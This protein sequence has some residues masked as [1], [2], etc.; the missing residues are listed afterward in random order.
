MTGGLCNDTGRLMMVFIPGA[1]RE[2]G[3]RSPCILLGLRTPQTVWEG[4]GVAAV[5]IVG[6]CD[7]RELVS[8]D[9][10]DVLIGGDTRAACVGSARYVMYL[11]IVSLVGSNLLQIV[12]GVRFQPTS[13][14]TEERSM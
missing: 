7:G 11:S 12:S 4:D 6:V 14:M 9:D 8:I 2:L 3:G 5:A 10:K 1:D 13:V